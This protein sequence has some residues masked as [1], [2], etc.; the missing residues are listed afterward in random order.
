MTGTRSLSKL[1]AELEQASLLTTRPVELSGS[2][3]VSSYALEGGS[4]PKGHWL[5]G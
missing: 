1:V 5:V 4:S 2:T 3:P